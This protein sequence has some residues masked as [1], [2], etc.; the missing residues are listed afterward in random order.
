MWQIVSMSYQPSA[1]D[2]PVSHRSDS[3]LRA[4][5]FMGWCRHCI[6]R[7]LPCDLLRN[8]AAPGTLQQTEGHCVPSLQEHSAAWVRIPSHW[9]S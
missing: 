6:L 3:P 5:L 7:A 1:Y 2:M 4:H 8:D 9:E